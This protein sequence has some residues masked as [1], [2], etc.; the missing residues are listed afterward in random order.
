ML[1]LADGETFDIIAS[2]RDGH[3]VE[4][5]REVS[6]RIGI[7]IHNCGGDKDKRNTR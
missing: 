5:G 4:R 3:L 7:G 6:W 1:L 2:G